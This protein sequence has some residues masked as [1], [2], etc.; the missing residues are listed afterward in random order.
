MGDEFVAGYTDGR[1][2]DCL[3]PG[4]NRSESYKHSFDIARREALNID[5][6]PAFLSR[7]RAR[8]IER[9][10]QHDG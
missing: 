3:P 2:L 1:D 4:E 6:T 9:N 7:S 5:P 10:E 8:E